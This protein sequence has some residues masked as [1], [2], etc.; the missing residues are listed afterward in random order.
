MNGTM[1]SQDPS[2]GYYTGNGPIPSSYQ[3]QYPS[4]FTT[5]VYPNQLYPPPMQSNHFNQHDNNNIQHQFY[6]NNNNNNQPSANT[7]TNVY[8]FENGA[9]IS[10]DYY[11]RVHAQIRSN[12]P[13]NYLN[14]DSTN[15]GTNSNIS[16]QPTPAV[17]NGQ[18]DPTFLVVAGNNMTRTSPPIQVI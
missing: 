6:P 12:T 11:N 8:N 18:I 3:S 17:F 5:N 14:S 13:G 1:Y 10:A 4:T 16:R 2:L 9:T 15:N 7:N